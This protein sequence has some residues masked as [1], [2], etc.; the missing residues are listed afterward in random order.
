MKLDFQIALALSFL[1]LSPS[2]I[3]ENVQDSKNIVCAT[4]TARP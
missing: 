4:S 1:A 2:L 3:A